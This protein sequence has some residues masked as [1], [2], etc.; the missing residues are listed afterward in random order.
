[1]HYAADSLVTRS[2]SDPAR[3]YQTNVQAARILL[4]ACLEYAVERFVHV[5]TDEV[6]EPI[7][8]GVFT[9][10]A[11]LE[12]DSQASSAYAKSKSRADDLVRAQQSSQCSRKS[13]ASRPGEEQTTQRGAGDGEAVPR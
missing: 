1:M 3:F 5:S 4:E 8:S 12:G 13:D 2:E 6:Y 11:K 7:E 10:N 9:Q